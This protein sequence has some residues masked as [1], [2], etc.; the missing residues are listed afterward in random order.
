M[1]AAHGIR[2]RTWVWQHCMVGNRITM[3]RRQP[4]TKCG[5]KAD[6]CFARAYIDEKL[7]GALAIIIALINVTTTNQVGLLR[8]RH[9]HSSRMKLMT[10]VG[11]DTYESEA[12]GGLRG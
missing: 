7:K 2:V 8:L 12:Q 5:R 3:L 9:R 11:D 6:T 4:D 1:V 10:A